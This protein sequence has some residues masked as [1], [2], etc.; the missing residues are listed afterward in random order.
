[1]TGHAA[2]PGHGSMRFLCISRLHS[3]PLQAVSFALECNLGRFFSS[4]F[5]LNTST[6]MQMRLLAGIR[7]RCHFETA[8]KVNAQVVCTTKPSA[9]A[10]P[11]VCSCLPVLSSAQQFAGRPWKYF[12]FFTVLG[13]SFLRGWTEHSPCSRRK[14]D[15]LLP[16]SS[17]SKS[18]RACPL[19]LHCYIKNV[20]ATFD[21]F[22]L[23]FV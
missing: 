13:Y 22:L 12:Q 19:S 10:A 6:F 4:G 20:T 23:T 5:V 16:S 15:G 14:S 17:G 8:I 9:V 2:G 18:C 21:M 3:E 11:F 7:K 1:M